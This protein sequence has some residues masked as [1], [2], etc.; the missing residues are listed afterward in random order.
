MKPAR[1][2][3]QRTPSQWWKT[4]GLS[5]AGSSPKLQ[6][7]NHPGYRERITTNIKTET[8]KI[9]SQENSSSRSGFSIFAVG[10]LIGAGIA[11]LYAPQSGKD[12]RKLLAQKARLLRDKAQLTVQNTQQFV[13]DGKADFAAAFDSGTKVAGANRS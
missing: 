13:K 6:E 1:I 8:E 12:T 9:M 3:I 10:A 7:N 4:C 11:L 2:Q 5:K